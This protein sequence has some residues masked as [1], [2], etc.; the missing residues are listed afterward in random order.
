[1]K[2]DNTTST[3]TRLNAH[4]KR[5]RRSIDNFQAEL[6]ECYCEDELEKAWYAGNEEFREFRYYKNE[7]EKKLEDLDNEEH[8]LL[9]KIRILQS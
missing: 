3:L 6:K 8:N 5:I 2:T 4:L 7:I 9:Y 1:M